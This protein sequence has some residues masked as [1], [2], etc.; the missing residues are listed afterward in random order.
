MSARHSRFVCPCSII[1]TSRP[2]RE[3]NLQ[4]ASVLVFL[5]AWPKVM[6]SPRFSLF[7]W[8]VC[9][10]TLCKNWRHQELSQQLAYYSLGEK[11]TPE[12]MQRANSTA[13]YT[14]N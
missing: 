10:L 14:V 2:T 3:F 5:D 9:P 12:K 6:A 8:R 13:F 7:G 4:F 11:A 1:S